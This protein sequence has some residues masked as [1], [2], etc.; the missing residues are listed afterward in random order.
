MQ[1]KKSEA[2]LNLPAVGIVKPTE[3]SKN[4]TSKTA[5]N[6]CREI[7]ERNIYFDMPS[8]HQNDLSMKTFL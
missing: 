6:K 7:D 4:Y 8:I 5:L 1:K 3:S 2:K